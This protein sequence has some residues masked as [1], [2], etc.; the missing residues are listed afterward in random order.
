MKRN[1]NL[2]SLEEIKRI[3]PAAKLLN[4]QNL[5]IRSD[6]KKKQIKKKP[7]KESGTNNKLVNRKRLKS[8]N[9]VSSDDEQI[10]S[11]DETETYTDSIILPNI[12]VKV[13]PSNT[14]EK[15]KTV[16]FN[17][18]ISY[19][20]QKSDHSKQLIGLHRLFKEF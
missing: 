9:S 7:V 20:Y 11:N 16:R 19:F 6:M 18:E 5:M 15:K 3:F 1:R 4:N 13:S 8:I 14:D 10:L 17:E 2:L 12:K